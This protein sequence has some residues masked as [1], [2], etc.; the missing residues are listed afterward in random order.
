MEVL[1]PE[2]LFQFFGL[3]LIS[4]EPQIM[5]TEIEQMIYGFVSSHFGLSSAS[6]SGETSFKE[7]LEADSLDIVEMTIRVEEAFGVTIDDDEVVNLET[8]SDVIALI[9][10][11]KSGMPSAEAVQEGA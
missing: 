6:L 11:S 3:N 9:E 7:D 10:K 8:I 5:P 1:L 4:G 2:S